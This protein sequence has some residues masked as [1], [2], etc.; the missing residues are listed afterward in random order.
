[1]DTHLRLMF[2]RAR[3]KRSH[4]SWLQLSCHGHLQ[5]NCS[6]GHD[7]L[8]HWSNLGYLL[9]RLGLAEVERRASSRYCLKR[10]QEAASSTDCGSF[11][12]RRK[13]WLD[14]GLLTKR[15]NVQLLTKFNSYRYNYCVSHS[16]CV[17]VTYPLFN[18]HTV[19]L[20]HTLVARV[21]FKHI[22]DKLLIELAFLCG[23]LRRIMMWHFVYFN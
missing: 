3:A 17:M 8:N 18:S 14:I 2:L 12:R 9:A 13:S 5:S 10:S 22:N 11:S 1:M 19:L 4:C 15:N 23:N 16:C 6:S 21:Y 20:H 7:Y